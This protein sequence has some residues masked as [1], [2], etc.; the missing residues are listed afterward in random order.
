M[1]LVLDKFATIS[2]CEPYSQH[3]LPKAYMLPPCFY[4]PA[5]LIALPSRSRTTASLDTSTAPNAVS[6]DNVRTFATTQG[7]GRLYRALSQC[8]KRPAWQGLHG[9][10][11]QSQHPSS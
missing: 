10:S 3:E 1:L 4:T 8:C 5:V 7:I 2:A 6:Y 11:N 9:N